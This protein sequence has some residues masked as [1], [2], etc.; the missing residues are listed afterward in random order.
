MRILNLIFFNFLFNS[1][2]LSQSIEEIKANHN[3]YF[4]GEGYGITLNRA[5]QDALGMLIRVC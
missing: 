1:L 4:W 5:D 2:L 3:K